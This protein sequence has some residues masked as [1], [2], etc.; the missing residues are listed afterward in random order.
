MSRAGDITAVENGLQPH[1]KIPTEPQKNILTRMQALNVPNASI[2]MIVDAE[3]AWSR[4]YDG[5]AQ[6][7]SDQRTDGHAP[8]FQAGSI[9]KTINAI[10]AMKLLV[11]ADEPIRIDLQADLT[12][13]LK[14]IGIQNKTGKPITLAQ[15]LSHTAGTTIHGFPGY[16]TNAKRFP[17][18]TEVLAGSKELKEYGPDDPDPQDTHTPNT[19]PVEI[20]RDPGVEHVY[21]GGGTTIVQQLIEMAYPNKTY[22]E[23]AQEHIFVPLGMTQSTFEFQFPG[24]SVEHI[25]Q[26][27]DHEGNVIAG[28]WR[29][30]PESAAAGLWTTTSDLAKF[31]I[32]VHQMS[33]GEMQNPILKQETV[34]KMLV[35]QPNSDFGLGFRIY[36]NAVGSPFGHGGVTDGFCSDFVFFPETQT[37][38]VICTNG[39]LGH[40]T[41]L[42]E[43]IYSG[44]AEHYDWPQRKSV[45]LTPAKLPE[46]ML[47]KCVGE[48]VSSDGI[49]FTSK[50]VN[51]QLQL[52]LPHFR[53]QELAELTFIPLSE[54]A[55]FCAEYQFEVTFDAQYNAMKFMDGMESKR[56]D[57]TLSA[58]D[59]THFV[60]SVYQAI[61]NNYVFS[62]RPEL[63][64]SQFKS[65]LA[66]E[67]E[68]I[69]RENP[70]IGKKEFSDK[71]NQFLSHIDP[72]LILQF[73]P[74][75]IHDHV[76][77]NRVVDDPRGNHSARFDL[78]TMK[79]PASFERK[80]KR[81]NYGFSDKAE[82]SVVPKNIGYLK[83]TDFLDPSRDHIGIVAKEKAHELL[84]SMRDKKAFI[85]DLR[86]SHGGS[87]E[88]VEYILSYLLNDSD[89]AKIQNGVYNTIQDASTGT[90]KDYRV[91][92]TEFCLNV[93]IRVLTD[94]HTFSA[95]EEMAYDL[96]Q[97]NQR[98]L[99]D[100]RIQ[101][102]GQ[103]TTGGAHPMTGFPLTS[104]D[105][106]ATQEISQRVNPDYFLWVPD[107]TSVNPYTG[108]NW[109]DGPKK[110]GVKPGVKPDIEI[111][112]SQNMLSVTVESL[113]VVLSAKDEVSVRDLT[114]SRASQSMGFITQNTDRAQQSG[115]P[116]KQQDADTA[117]TL[118]KK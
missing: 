116:T 29:V 32:A 89:K 19:V 16:P 48:F 1:R 95:A 14:A 61:K 71:I 78:S 20:V 83:I 82:D 90:V 18:T 27:H 107:R 9:S 52:T 92:R 30:H 88:M 47:Q 31:A 114:S 103:K 54:T 109:E 55:F 35:R 104:P 74:A 21:S 113:C 81:E 96:Q 84:E 5:I 77:Q 26:G 7:A 43:E 85:I 87:P 98:A 58:S 65:A 70:R 44:I 41:Q 28:G 12:A 45:T 4:D 8:V 33:L 67:I 94:E 56:N 64:E 34:K 59:V 49:I 76:T 97:I 23:L 93:P 39:V 57:M 117:S 79:P 37:G 46:A 15:L 115:L 62:D 111:P 6:T 22:A 73:D 99:Q 118:G 86:G 3:V 110:T 91:R 68:T 108:T 53:R 42:V 75:Q 69:K 25:Q 60:E 80:F 66:Q 17:T 10:L 51:G 50:I 2:T 11:E 106:D 72:H 24:R 40:G 36:G 100:N 101:V 102:V 63:E 38:A 112:V 105:S 13:R